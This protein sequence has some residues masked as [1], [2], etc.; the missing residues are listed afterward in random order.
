MSESHSTSPPGGGARVSP[1]SIF[2]STGQ[3]P[4][5]S[6][7]AMVPQSVPNDDR[8]PLRK[9]SLAGSLD[10][11]ERQAREQTPL[12]GDLCLRGQATVWYA[13][14]NV[15]KTLIT[16]HLLRA[17]IEQSKIEGPQ[18][19]YVNADDSSAGVLEKLKI[20]L[21]F[22]VHVLAPGFNDLQAKDLPRT[23][24][25]MIADDTVGGTFLILDTLKKFVP[26]MDKRESSAFA[27]IARQF[28]MKGGSILG[29]AHTNKRLGTDG[30]PIFAGTS[31]I[32]DDFDG[33]FTIV[34]LAQQSNRT[35]RIV[36]FDCIKSRGNLA[37]QVAYA[38]S[39]EN[40]LSYPDLLDSVRLVDAEGVA[41]I[42]QEADQAADSEVIAA[43][44]KCIH[45]GMA[46]K[47]EIAR[48]VTERCRV[49]RQSACRII[50]KYTGNDPAIHLWTVR[51]G[52][53]GKQDFVLLSDAP[54]GC[55]PGE[56]F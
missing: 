44:E 45:E 22:G 16:L 26:L 42:I 47:M 3:A 38:Y 19:Y 12:L 37:Q 5:A 52:N 56:I 20:L 7:A 35:E 53:R 32:L 46:G 50:E 14:P 31:D 25:S 43:I 1:E 2:F 29:L 15:G 55:A 54:N 27:D 4:V 23:L 10:E 51:V 41:Q 36:Q 11:L 8:N 34:E 48:A 40:G 6:P 24:Q 21:P 39:L 28:V 13:K 30:K 18:V 33:G 17:S 49:G 9:F